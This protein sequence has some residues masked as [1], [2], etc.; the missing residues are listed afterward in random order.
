MHIAADV[1]DFKTICSVGKQCPVK[2]AHHCLRN[3][4]VVIHS[5]AINVRVLCV[6]DQAADTFNVTAR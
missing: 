3:A 5:I 2:I 4:V 6:H 1:M